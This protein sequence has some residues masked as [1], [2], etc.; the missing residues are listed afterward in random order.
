MKKILIWTL[1]LCSANANAGGGWYHLID[2]SASKSE[3]R[4]YVG[5]KWTLDEGMK[6]QAVVGFRHASLNANGN[7]DGGDLSISAK[8][9]DGFQLG[10]FRAKY[11]NGKEDVQGELGGGYDFTK[12]IFAGVGLHAPYSL[13]GLDM[14]PFLSDSKF[15]P[16]V[17]LDTNKGYNKPLGRQCVS[18][19]GSPN[20]IDASCSL[21]APSDR[22][23]KHDIRLLTQ[24]ASGVK[25]YSFKYNWSNKTYVGVMAQD[26]LK[27]VSTKGAVYIAS[28]GFYVVDYAKLG[29]KMTTLDELNAR[30]IFAMQ[31]N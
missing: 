16:Y 2:G 8:L 31:A 6:P 11:F 21:I 22:R 19:S 28:N 23:L 9:F 29:L 5:L 30:G 14:H 1:L 12:G 10:Q 17:Q 24:L 7:T 18:G 26:L 4:G 20:Y 27:R 25:V 13:L 3:S 15:E